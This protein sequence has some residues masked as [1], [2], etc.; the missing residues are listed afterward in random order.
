MKKNIIYF[1][2]A[3]TTWPKLDQTKKIV[4]EYF[5]EC[6]VS[7]NRTNKKID[8]LTSVRESLLKYFDCPPNFDVAIVPSATIG[9]N[10]VIASLLKMKKTHIIT[11]NC[12]HH[13]VYRPLT[14]LNAKFDIV[15]YLDSN[16]NEHPERILDK[17]DKDTNAIIMN[18]ASN[19][20]GQIF[21]IKRITC[22]L[23]QKNV[24]F[25]LDISQSAGS[26]DISLKKMNVD[27]AVGSIHKHLYG[28]PGIG[29]IIFNKN[30]ELY[31]IYF[32]GT[33][34]FSSNL[35]QPDILPDKLEAGTF[36]TIGLL[37]ILESLKVVNKQF[38]ENARKYENE[39][40]NY[41]INSCEDI[42]KVKIYGKSLKHRTSVISFNVEDI[43]PNFV[44]APLLEKNNILV[45]AGLH[46]A[47]I[48]HK[49][50]NTYP[51]GTVRI[52][53][54]KFNTKEEIDALVKILK[55][56]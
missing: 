50:M 10:V 36:N 25:V 37:S 20:N 45:R 49:T 47:P 23:K 15:D 33:G 26:E 44:V 9:M 46:C 21:D 34:K 28:T 35:K 39:L 11:T 54:S 38:R 8:I 19:V 12:E 55:K 13:C 17:V 22:N 27:I 43:N 1:D 40:V 14:E 4:N 53:F 32:G 31:P 48:I 41:F 52:S 18:H 16:Y 24:I 30:I 51:E 6:Y 42:S 7:P 56:F 29:Y 5:E 3:A 2:N